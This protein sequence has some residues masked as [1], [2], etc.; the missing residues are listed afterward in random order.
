[1]M[2][3]QMPSRTERDVELA[4]GGALELWRHLLEGKFAEPRAAPERLALDLAGRYQVGDGNE[5]PCEAPEISALGLAIKGPKI[6]RPGDSCLANLASVGIV[7]GVVVQAQQ[8]SFTLGVVATP[9]RMRR[10]AERLN[11]QLRH[12]VEDVPERRASERVEMN[13]A[14]GRLETDTGQVYAARIFDVSEGGAALHLGQSALYFWVDQPV[15]FDGRAAKVLR[16]F[17][18]GIVIKYD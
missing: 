18:G 5:F 11:W 3:E 8:Q 17:P 7:E 6:G 9:R 10:L 2:T 16:Y 14:E 12:A 15:A 1:M 13:S 4:R